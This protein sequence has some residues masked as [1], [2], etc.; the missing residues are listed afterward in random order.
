[1]TEKDSSILMLDSL[2]VEF[3]F[4]NALQNFE[5]IAPLSVGFQYCCVEVQ[6]HY[7]S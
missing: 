3:S 1:M 6:S 7:N 2:S 4:G 5:G